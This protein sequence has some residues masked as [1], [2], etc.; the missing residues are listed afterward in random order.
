[1]LWLNTGEDTKSNWELASAYVNFSTCPTRRPPSVSNCTWKYT[2]SAV[3]EAYKWTPDKS[4]KNA[5]NINAQW[6]HS[7]KIYRLNINLNGRF[8]SKRFSKSYGYAPEYQLWDLNTRHSFNLKSVIIEPG[9]GMENLFDY[10]DDRPYNS[11]YATLT[12]GRSFYISLSL[13][14]KS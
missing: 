14:F 6:A 4:I 2:E 8:N 12:P 13:K 1:M 3:F 9:C 11:N 10:M 5:Y 7:W